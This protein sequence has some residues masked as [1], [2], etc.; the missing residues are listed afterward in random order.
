[1]CALF[2]HQHSLKHTHE[3]CNADEPSKPHTRALSMEERGLQCSFTTAFTA[4]FTTA[5]TTAVTT[6]VTTA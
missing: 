6:A 4:D 2:R 3:A 5:F 1:M